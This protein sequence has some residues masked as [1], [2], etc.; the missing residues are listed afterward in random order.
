[1]LWGL[2]AL[3]PC[4]LALSPIRD[5]FSEGFSYFVTSI[6]APAASGWSGCRVGLAPTGKAPPYHGAHPWRTL[7]RALNVRS[8][9][10]AGGDVEDPSS[11]LDDE[12]EGRERN[13]SDATAA[14][15]D[16]INNALTKQ[17]R[18]V[19]IQRLIG[20]TYATIAAE[21]RPR[22]SSAS[23][24]R[25]IEQRAMRKLQQRLSRFRDHF[26]RKPGKSDL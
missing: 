11:Y 6:A 17:E 2:L 13:L 9:D 20:D 14:L 5:T 1:M 3:R 15:R 10:A 23:Q 26:T 7:R 25:K 19:L 16:V 4:T 12:I 8:L 22:L 21:C 18:R 24:A